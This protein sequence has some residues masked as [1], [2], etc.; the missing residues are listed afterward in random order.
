MGDESACDMINIP[1][2]DIQ[3][4]SGDIPGRMINI[5][6]DPWKNC[7]KQFSKNWVGRKSVKRSLCSILEEMFL[8]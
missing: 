1:V 6:N 3:N 8:K 4:C 7:L 5:S 2:S